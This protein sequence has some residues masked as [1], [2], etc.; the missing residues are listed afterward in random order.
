M[1]VRWAMG[2]WRTFV[3]YCSP[4]EGSCQERT[5][6]SARDCKAA[7]HTWRRKPVPKRKI[8]L[9]PGAPERVQYDGAEDG[10]GN[11][12]VKVTRVAKQSGPD[13]CYSQTYREHSGIQAAGIFDCARGRACPGGGRKGR[14]PGRIRGVG[15]PLRAQNLSPGDEHHRKPR[16]RRGR[17]AGSVPEVLLAPQG[18][19]RR[20]AVLYLAGA[21][22]RQRSPDEA[23]QAEALSDFARRAEGF[24]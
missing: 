20:L 1:A 22:R 3:R 8:I 6:F 23:P 18:I 5:P 7:R 16:R 15:Q 21:H 10:S 4:P 17:D 24:Q 13:W 19:S 9:D 12:Q 14:R 11:V 2:L